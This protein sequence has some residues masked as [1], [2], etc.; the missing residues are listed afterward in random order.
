MKG[1]SDMFS[2][3]SFLMLMIIGFVLSV[4]ITDVIGENLIL[5]YTKPNGDVWSYDKDSIK[6]SSGKVKVWV[7]VVFSK[8]SISKEIENIKK[9]PN[10]PKNVED[11][12]YYRGLVEINCKEEKIHDLTGI[13]Y[14]RNG[15]EVYI[16]NVSGEFGSIIPGS[17]N[18]ELKNRVC[19]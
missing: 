1:S 14:D 13:F 10:T 18:G 15:N 19:K 16:N 7:T 3:K 17:I 4:F 2:R 9:Y 11:I 8:E 5:L 6:G 12:S